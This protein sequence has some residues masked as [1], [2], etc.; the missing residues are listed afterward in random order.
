MSELTKPQEAPTE[1]Q[2]A[3]A[4]RKADHSRLTYAEQSAALKLHATGKN[5]VEI[6]QALHCHSSTICR[7]LAEF[8]P[9][10]DA[11][12]LRLQSGADTLAR[13]VI[14]N[15]DVDQSLELLDRLE[16]APK[17]QSDKG[18]QIQIIQGINLPGMGS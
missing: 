9:T 12:K 2:I 15:A 7:L 10:I 16:V 5:Q 3:P 8:T 18:P 4:K 14:K 17:R 6:A 1:A 11:A 13:R